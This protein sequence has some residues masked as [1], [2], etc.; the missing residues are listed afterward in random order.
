MED[1]EK[2]QNTAMKKRSI[3]YY[4]KTNALIS[5]YII[6]LVFAA[7]SCRNDEKSKQPDVSE[8]N[9]IEIIY[10]DNIMD[11]NHS[12]WSDQTGGQ[13]A[14]VFTPEFYPAALK[15]V[16]FFVSH[17]GVPTA[18]FGVRVYSGSIE[19]GPD[20]ND[21]LKSEVTGS[22]EAVM[23]LEWVEVDLS[24]HNIQFTSGD[25]FVAM[26]WLTPPGISGD[27]AQFIG[28]DYSQ[29]DRRSWWK[30]DLSSPWKRIE[31]IE[32]DIDRDVMIRATVS[33]K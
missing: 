17:P 26:E 31:E 24:D 1:I 25:F 6:T 22:A 32:Y 13:L 27:N 3:F 20:D 12:P 29:P 4:L 16:R 28:V 5:L 14:V 23:G 33:K 9:E 18:E 19:D 8:G 11:G 21:L 30:T 2:G 10:D 7:S 15:K